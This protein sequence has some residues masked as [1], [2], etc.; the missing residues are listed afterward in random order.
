[1]DR[2]R[3][4]GGQLHGPDAL[5]PHGLRR[6]ARIPRAQIVVGDVVRDVAAALVAGDR[7]LADHEVGEQLAALQLLVQAFLGRWA[8]IIE[9]REPVL[10]GGQVEA[11]RAHRLALVGRQRQRPGQGLRDDRARQLVVGRQLGQ[12]APGHQRLDARGQVAHRMI[13]REPVDLLLDRLA[14]RVALGRRAAQVAQEAAEVAGRGALGDRVRQP[15]AL[16][17]VEHRVGTH[18]LGLVHQAADDDRQNQD[19]G[20]REDADPERLGA[21]VLD[22]LALGDEVDLAHR[23]S[24]P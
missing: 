21:H 23:P 9:A 12:R 8:E 11:E 15:L 13:G 5:L 4:L 1:L 16:G 14:H 3:L 2:A 22:E 20:E 10:V 6:V 7:I 19:D 24:L 18:V 17:L